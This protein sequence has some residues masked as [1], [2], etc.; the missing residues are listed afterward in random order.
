[1]RATSKRLCFIASM[2]LS[3]KTLSGCFEPTLARGLTA[4]LLEQAAVMIRS[5]ANS[6]MR[7]T[8]RDIRPRLK[9]FCVSITRTGC[10]VMLVA[11]GR[12]S[13]ANARIRKDRAARLESCP[14]LVRFPGPIFEQFQVLDFHEHCLGRCLQQCFRILCWIAAA[15]HGV[16]R[17]QNFRTGPD[18]VRHRVERHPTIYFDAVGQAALAANLG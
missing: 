12:P 15:E 9:I 10:A 1:M 14:A 16:A 7:E 2:A 5:V 13:G 3:T 4:F 6:A 8:R 11:K 18:H 17:H